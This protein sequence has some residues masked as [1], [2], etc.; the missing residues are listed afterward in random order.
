MAHQLKGSAGSFGYP[1]LTLCAGELERAAR[2]G[3]AHEAGA[4][5]AQLLGLDELNSLNARGSPDVQQ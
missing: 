3:D 1:G 4:A 5:L 2:R